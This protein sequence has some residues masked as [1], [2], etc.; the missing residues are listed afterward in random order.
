MTVKNNKIKKVKRIYWGL[1]PEIKE[2]YTTFIFLVPGK[3]GDFIRGIYAHRNFKRCGVNPGIAN[4]VRIF[5]PQK[6]EVGDNIRIADYVQIS[7]GGGV[8][9]GNRVMIAPF[10]KIWSNNHRFDDLDIP[11]YDQGWTVD[12]VIIEDDVFIAMG[13]IILPG[14]HIGKGCII[15]AGTVIG[16]K[17]IKPY[18][19]IAG[20]PGRVIGSRINK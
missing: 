1:K 13:S 14:A 4:H 10:V 7:A 8:S 11:I 17:E 16:K 12:A 15:S 20:N 6:F 2:W 5:N 19:I 9:F 18:S 3:I